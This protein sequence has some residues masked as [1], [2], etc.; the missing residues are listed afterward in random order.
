[1]L[2]IIFT[3]VIALISSYLFSQDE[4]APKLLIKNNIKLIESFMFEDETMNDS[5]L[6]EKNTLTIVVGAKK[7][8]SLIIQKIWFRNTFTT[9]KMIP[10]ELNELL[11]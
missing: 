4:I 3:T 6:I 1:M 10:L 9:T 8:K 7:L 5:F 2:K 11:Y